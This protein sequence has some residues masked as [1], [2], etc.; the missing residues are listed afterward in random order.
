RLHG[1]DIGDH[2]DRQ[3]CQQDHWGL[4]RQVAA[5][6]THSLVSFSYPPF[7]APPSCVN[8]V[9]WRLLPIPAPP[10]PR[11][12]FAIA[13]PG[14]DIESGIPTEFGHSIRIGGRL[15]SWF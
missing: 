5:K 3:S 2:A 15:P 1:V 7:A 6:H 11:V 9:K 4:P 14:D 8:G 10:C 13:M 12:N